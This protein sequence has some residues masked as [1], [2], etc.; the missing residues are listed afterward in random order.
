MTQRS[1]S[2]KLLPMRKVHNIEQVLGVA[3]ILPG[4]LL[5]AE[6]TAQE[7]VNL[8]VFAQERLLEL[9]V[10]PA[11]CESVSSDLLVAMTVGD[12]DQVRATGFASKPTKGEIGYPTDQ[13][14]PHHFAEVFFKRVPLSRNRE[15]QPKIACRSD[16]SPIRFDEC[17]DDSYVRVKAEWMEKPI[18]LEGE[19]ND[20]D[21]ETLYAAVDS[22][23]LLSRTDGLTVTSDN[24]Y[25]IIKY[26]Y[27]GNR[28]NV[29]VTTAKDGYTDAI[30]FSRK[31]EHGVARYVVSDFRCGVD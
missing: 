12:I 26:E 3:L 20:E 15:Y 31:E 30:Y 11:C 6:Y 17:Y 4:L 9:A 13:W 27:A 18:R 25:H 29:Y 24:I 10:N 2:K 16:G 1:R 5:G 21:I 23:K 14:T 22:A 8:P 19:V 7:E 28:V